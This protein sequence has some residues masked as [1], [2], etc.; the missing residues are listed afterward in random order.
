MRH[1]LG[2]PFLTVGRCDDA[3]AGLLPVTSSIGGSISRMRSRQ[4]A[5]PTPAQIIV[6]QLRGSNTHCVA[7]AQRP[8]LTNMHSSI[9]TSHCGVGILHTSWIGLGLSEQR[10]VMEFEGAVAHR[11]KVESKEVYSRPPDRHLKYTV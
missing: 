10:C 11:A 4:P 5:R 8:K 9:P 1:A 3:I 2:R 6:L 7:G